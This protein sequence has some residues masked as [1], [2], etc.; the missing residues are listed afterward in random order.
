MNVKTRALARSHVVIPVAVLLACGCS[1]LTASAEEVRM[2]TVSFKDLS[3]ETPAGIQALYNRIHAAAR[4]VCS[5]TDP[6]RRAGAAGC[7]RQAEARAVQSVGNP[8]LTA[9]FQGKSGQQ[10]TLLAA[11]KR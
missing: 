4:R 6:V 2:E 8:Q 3:L 7:A 11:A 5:E 1:I 10:P 9:F